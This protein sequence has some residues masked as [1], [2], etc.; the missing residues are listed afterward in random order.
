LPG[1]LAVLVFSVGL[2]VAERDLDG[3]CVHSVSLRKS[4]P[5]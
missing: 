3:L 1:H 4:S 2:A 5:V